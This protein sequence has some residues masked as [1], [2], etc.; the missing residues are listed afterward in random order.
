MN[1][2]QISRMARSLVRT[3]GGKDAALAEAGRQIADEETRGR[4]A[5]AEN[6]RAIRDAVLAVD[7]TVGAA[8]DDDVREAG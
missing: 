6:W 2:M 7:P 3:E 1:R 4:E 8:P 5:E